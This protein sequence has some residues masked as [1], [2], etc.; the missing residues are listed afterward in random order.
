MKT[1]LISTMAALLCFG[2][3]QANADYSVDRGAIQMD[4]PQDIVITFSQDLGEL[5]AKAKVRH[6]DT[7]SVEQACLALTLAQM[8]RNPAMN[9]DNDEVNVTLFLRNDGVKLADTELVDAISRLQERGKAP[10]CI[11]PWY[12]YPITLEQHL[13][14]FLSGPLGDTNDLV[15]CP[16]CWCAYKGFT[17]P[18]ECRTDYYAD[19]P[20]PGVLDPTAVPPL[21]LGADKVVDF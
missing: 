17:D 9:G 5:R 8:L 13:T 2:S 20:Y 11:A 4:S 1:A 10:G 21:F 18:N 12:P 6:L 3:V 16:I 7:A 15:N 19:P 14:D